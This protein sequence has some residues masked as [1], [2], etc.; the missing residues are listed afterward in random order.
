VPADHAKQSLS[1][2][3]RLQL[4]FI[5]AIVEVYNLGP[6]G[7]LSP[8]AAN[9]DLFFFLVRCPTSPLRSKSQRPAVEDD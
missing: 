2:A 3:Y 5:G 9:I 6:L 7:K 8:T 1:E 4:A